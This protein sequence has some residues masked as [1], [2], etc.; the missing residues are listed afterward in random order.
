MKFEGIFCEWLDDRACAEGRFWAMAFD[1]H[2][3]SGLEKGGPDE[4]DGDADEEQEY[5]REREPYT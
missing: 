4:E 2:I 1:L 3:L 5:V